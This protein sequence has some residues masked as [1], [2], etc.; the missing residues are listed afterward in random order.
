MGA[1]HHPEYINASGVNSATDYGWMKT[2]SAP[3]WPESK[4][5]DVVTSG[6]Q[7]WNKYT[8]T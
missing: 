2:A 4:Y 1:Q 7:A 5:E 8:K 3:T 6:I